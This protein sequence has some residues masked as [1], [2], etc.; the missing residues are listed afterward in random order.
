MLRSGAA[1]PPLLMHP[2]DA[3]RLGLVDAQPVRLASTVGATDATVAVTDAIRPGVVSLPHGWPTPGVN[4]L[5]SATAGVD[6]LTGM[7]LLTGIAVEVL[8]A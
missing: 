5:T 6:P 4:E 1:P 3:T 2:D 8:P 7:P